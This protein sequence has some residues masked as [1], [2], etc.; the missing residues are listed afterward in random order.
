[1]AAAPL[2]LPRSVR[3]RCRPHYLS[4]RPD[5]NV[6]G[7]LGAG[8]PAVEQ[9]GAAREAERGLLP[10]W[11]PRPQRAPSRPALG[12][13][14][15]RHRRSRGRRG[16][17]AAAAAAATATEPGR[18]EGGI[19]P[20]AGSAPPASPR[21]LHPFPRSLPGSAGSPA[22]RG[23]RVRKRG[24]R[25]N[26]PRPRR[27]RRRRGEE[28]GAAAATGHRPLLGLTV[29]VRTRRGRG[30]ETGSTP[31]AAPS[32][33][34]SPP[35]ASPTREP[36][37]SGLAGRDGVP[38]SRVVSLPFPCGCWLRFGATTPCGARGPLQRLSRSVKSKLGCSFLGCR[39]LHSSQK[40]AVVP[41][42]RSGGQRSSDVHPLP[43]WGQPGKTCCVQIN[44]QKCYC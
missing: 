35:R 16:N 13:Q 5:P 25:E 42:P 11:P 6:R 29:A 17:G 32:L 10:R 3:P 33:G 14:P 9:V 41:P 2:P 37:C 15:G 8:W 7:T 12:P 4:R 40:V 1:M 31:A 38:R 43:Q 23:A 21:H 28:R 30:A 27:A 24:K 20:Q 19:S 44:T 26:T 22:A 34:P 18:G 36:G 39:C